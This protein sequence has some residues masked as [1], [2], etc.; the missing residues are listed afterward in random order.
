MTPCNPT[1]LTH[2]SRAMLS[3][4][5]LV[6]LA[7]CGPEKPPKFTSNSPSS[8]PS[9]APAATPAPP[10]V[11][12]AP[13]AAPDNG[14]KNKALVAKVKQALVAQKV[15]NAHQ[16]DVTAEDGKVTLFGAVNDNQDRA[17]AERVASS[18][19]GVTAVS[20]NLAIAA[21]S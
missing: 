7:A 3:A 21:G 9:S 19:D 4:A 2:L 18:V 17:T 13:R 10:P 1:S 12:E 14:D 15:E 5:L 16:I 11:A 6:G 20:N 8:P